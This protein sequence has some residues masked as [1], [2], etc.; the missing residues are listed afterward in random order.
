MRPGNDRSSMAGF[1]ERR[2]PERPCLESK[3]A[4]EYLTFNLWSEPEFMKLGKLE[5]PSR[6]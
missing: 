4:L 6:S 1:A 2:L 3:R 5:S